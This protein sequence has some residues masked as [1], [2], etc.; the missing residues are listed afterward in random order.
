MAVG[1]AAVEAVKHVVSTSDASAAASEAIAAVNDVTAAGLEAV[2][3]AIPGTEALVGAVTAAGEAVSGGVEGA[4]V[5]AAGSA[6]A[7]EVGSSAAAASI[8][9]DAAV[10]AV[11]ASAAGAAAVEADAAVIA[12]STAAASTAAASTSTAALDTIAGTAVTKAALSTAAVAAF[13]KFVSFS[14]AKD[15]WATY[16]GLLGLYP[17]ATK[18]ATGSFLYSLSDGITQGAVE[19][20]KAEE[21]DAGR[22]RRFAVWGIL[23]A[24]MATTWYNILGGWTDALFPEGPVVDVGMGIDPADVEAHI[25]WTKVAFEVTADQ[26][27]YCP[28]WFI[29]FFTFGG[30]WEKRPFGDTLEYMKKEIG[31]AVT[32]SWWVWLPVMT[33]SFGFVSQELRVPYYLI[34][35]FLYAMLLSA[36]WGDVPGEGIGQKEEE[37]CDATCVSTVAL[38]ALT[39]EA[40]GSFDEGDDQSTGES[41]G[42]ANERKM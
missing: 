29:V 20:R 25:N 14:L 24:C 2:V 16:S 5:V 42:E 13:K 8:E 12:A 3:D 26:L 11:T 33:I 19:E 18:S 4:A 22:I 40:S 1:G 32:T 28:V 17:L 27:I 30:A 41:N 37:E 9:M 15:M 39:L 10:A 36:L 34:M 21:I 31:P 38:G 35:S 6:A 7:V 23:D